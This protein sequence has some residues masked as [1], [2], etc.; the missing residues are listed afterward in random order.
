MPQYHLFLE[1]QSP[2]NIFFSF[3]I[4]LNHFC[5]DRSDRRDRIATEW[6][7]ALK[8]KICID[9]FQKGTMPNMTKA[10]EKERRAVSRVYYDN[11]SRQSK[12][13]WSDIAL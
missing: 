13:K 7:P 1:L 6:K 8:F 5:S 2:I 4:S 3:P 11:G 9:G 12:S 10:P